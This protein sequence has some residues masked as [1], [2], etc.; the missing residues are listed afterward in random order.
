MRILVIED[1][2]KDTEFIRQAL[3]R[4]EG[5]ACRI[6]HAADAASALNEIRSQAFDAIIL[7]LSLPD[8]EGLDTLRLLRARAPKTPL[9]VLTG[10]DSDLAGREAIQLGA[11]DYLVKDRINERAVARCLR[12]AVERRRAQAALIDAKNLFRS[13]INSFQ[14]SVAILDESGTV[15]SINNS[16]RDSC[17]NTAAISPFSVTVND[18]YL[19]LCD[20]LGK[21]GSCEAAHIAEALRAV[22][23]KAD[24]SAEVEWYCH[25][26]QSPRWVLTRL[27]SFD[28]CDTLRVA[29]IHDNVT[30]RKSAEYLLKKS[31]EKARAIAELAKDAILTIDAEGRISYWNR[32]ATE[33]FGYTAEEALGKDMHALLAPREYHDAFQ[34]G[35]GG[36]SEDGQGNIVGKTLELEALRKSGETFP[37]ELSVSGFQLD[38]KW[39]AIG[40]VRDATE[41]KKLERQ[42]FS[43]QRLDSLGKLAGGVAHDF[44]N[45][46]TIISGRAQLLER[47]ISGSGPLREHVEA[48]VETSMKAAA[49]TGQL[50]AFARKQP[51]KHKPTNLNAIIQEMEANLLPL[52]G[53]DI[54]LVTK[55][56]PRIPGVLGDPAQLEQVL[57]NLAINARD[58]MPD[59]GVLTIE[60]KNGE[61]P[62]ERAPA[63][64]PPEP[65]VHLTVSDTGVG[66]DEQTQTRLFEPFFTTKAPGQGNGLGLATVYGIVSQHEAAIRVSSQKG[67]GTTFDLYFPKTLEAKEALAASPRPTSTFT[68][69]GSETVLVVED[70]GGVRRLT[71]Q[72]L[73]LAGY[74][75]LEAANG[76]EALDA[77]AGHPGEVDLVVTDVQMPG[78][79]GIEL[80]ARLAVSHPQIKVILVS[81]Y[82][83]HAEPGDD[84]AIHATYILEKPF[85]PESLEQTVR[86]ALDGNS[87]FAGVD[88]CFTE[89]K[90][91]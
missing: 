17:R 20:E 2:P 29:V 16:W 44:N 55:L 22:L 7:D 91:V 38:G 68:G 5:N 56:E 77:I 3:A 40:I 85:T 1:D 76:E 23:H 88:E 60:T 47:E 67:R 84:G 43:A 59:G 39:N 15:L 9:I 10:W 32:A 86:D 53:D 71:C 61:F 49:L 72:I 65:C 34:Q 19:R 79:G 89:S 57:L 27:H 48:I 11:D 64:V 52:L 26:P 50:L 51:H 87:H 24:L 36:F 78:M 46:L 75:V 74:T 4:A 12:Y 28:H 42:L 54:R 8:S 35:F 6:D 21:Q 33:I 66:M 45:L 82:T 37:I 14:S 30:Q 80:A 81:G 41:R 18:N 69:R 83:D 90:G 25:D 58:A 31:E 62:R 63:A 13:T 70:Q 73:K